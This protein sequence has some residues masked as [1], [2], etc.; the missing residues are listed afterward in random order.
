MSTISSSLLYQ[1]P[2]SAALKAQYVGQKLKDIQ[3]PAAIIDLAVVKKNCNLM[4]EAAESLK[5]QF[6]AHVKTHKT[7][8]LAQ[9][10]AGESGP[11]RLILAHVL[12][13]SKHISLMVDHVETLSFISRSSPLWPGGPIRIF[14]KIDTGYH[15]SG[16]TFD[17]SQLNA[18]STALSKPETK[19]QISLLGLYSHLGHS[20]AFNTPTEAIQGLLTELTSLAKATTTIQQT[21]GPLVLSV[22]ATPT[23]TAAQTLSSPSPLTDPAQ[24]ETADSLHTHLSH[25]KSKGLIP[26]LHAGVYPVLD[27]Q[28][29]ATHS[30]TTNLT[31]SD[32]GLTILAEVSSLY[33]DR[34]TPEA[35]ISAGSLVLGREPCKS[36]PGWGVVTPWPEPTTI[37]NPTSPPPHYSEASKTGWIVGRVSQEHGILTWQS[38]TG[39]PVSRELVIG[40]KVMIWPNHACVAGSG[41]GWYF[42]VDSESGDGDVVRDVWVRCRGW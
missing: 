29:L 28:Q 26:E 40:Q 9:L 19:E 7:S 14:V 32:I 35:L 37:A 25:L 2:S 41:F 21:H 11:V 18:I 27:M 30:R 34:A 31:P 4:L 42:V 38:P 24:K 15:R 16:V 39:S 5:V 1:I 8:E 10:Q 13:S 22:G 20:Y 36:Y 6:R 17:S 3:A 12:G 33:P 23:A